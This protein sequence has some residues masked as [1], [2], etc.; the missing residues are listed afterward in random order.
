[1]TKMTFCDLIP[2]LLSI[3]YLKDSETNILGKN[4][5]IESYISALIAKVPK[6][7]FRKMCTISSKNNFLTHCSP[8]HKKL[9]H[10]CPISKSRV[11]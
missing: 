9:K 10:I 2:V 4:F 1:M 5:D 8:Y 7:S 3:W 11:K 6:L